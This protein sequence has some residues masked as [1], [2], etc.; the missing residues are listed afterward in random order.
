LYR[1]ADLGANYGLARTVSLTV[2]AVNSFGSKTLIGTIQQSPGVNCSAPP[3][4]G[5]NYAGCDL[6]DN[7]WV[8]ANL[9][10]ADLAGANLT[11]ANLNGANL[12]NAILTGATLSSASL[13]NANLTGANLSSAQLLSANF[14]G[15]S[16]TNA[17][18]TSANA[19]G[20]NFT[21]VNLT[22]AN[23]S[24]TIIN[25]DN[26]DGTNLTGTHLLFTPY[27][28]GDSVATNGSTICPTGLAGPCP[29]YSDLPVWYPIQ[30]N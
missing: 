29:G 13:T 20:T 10:S 30:S 15:A 24:S 6:A 17:N 3:G 28:P 25:G 27:V 22:G 5:A 11:Q 26:M 23:F 1:A 7:N 16:M 14:T 9:T 18:L 4:P 8:L 19:S 2:K 21:N 12:T